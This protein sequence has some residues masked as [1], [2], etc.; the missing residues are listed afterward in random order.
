MFIRGKG[1]VS[2]FGE[3][4]QAA[5]N[6]VVKDI[7]L[8]MV[9]KIEKYDSILIRADVQPL[10]KLQDNENDIEVDLPILTDL[11]V[12]HYNGGGFFIKPNYEPGDLVWIGFSTHDYADALREYS[13]VKSDKKF[14]LHNA[15]VL[16][17]IVKDFF[18]GGAAFLEEGIVLGKKTGLPEPVIKGTT[19]N[20]ALET[21]LTSLSGLVGGSTAQNAAAITAIASAATTFKALLETW[22]SLDVKVT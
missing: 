1:T 17:G 12:L 15:V 6:D 9:A 16:G 14:E 22:K 8:G 4:I 21:F 11:P 3:F 20:T 13:R 10:M 18:V 7:Q 5:I 19:Y 2:D